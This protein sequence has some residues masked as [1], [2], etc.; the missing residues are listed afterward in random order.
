MELNNR[1]DSINKEMDDID[2]KIDRLQRKNEAERIAL[3][4]IL[5]GLEKI[6]K[7]NPKNVEVK[8]AKK[9]LKE[10]CKKDNRTV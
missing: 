1:A 8:K 5:E 4:K 9:S 3:K 7:S 6:G 2:E 10:I